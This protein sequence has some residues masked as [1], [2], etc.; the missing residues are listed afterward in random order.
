MWYHSD[1]N[2]QR[3]WRG[4]RILLHL[5]AVDWETTVYLNG[6]NL[7]G[8]RGGYDAFTFDLT[9]HLDPGQGAGVGRSVLDPTDT[10]WHLHGKQTLQPAGCSYTATSGIWQTVWLEP[11]PLTTS[12]ETVRAVPDRGKWR[13]EDDVDRSR[14]Q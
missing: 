6:K 4:Q 5:G 9:R 13:V 2:S 1:H 10:T 3:A 11:V 14:G 12:I 8:H 7:G